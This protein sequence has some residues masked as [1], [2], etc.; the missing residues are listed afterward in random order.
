MLVA[1]ARRHFSSLKDL[2][3]ETVR[4]EAMMTDPKQV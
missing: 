3:L 4:R 1:I 2:Y